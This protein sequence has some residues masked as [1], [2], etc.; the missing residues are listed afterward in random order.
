LS[1]GIPFNTREA[2]PIDTSALSATSRN[3]TDRDIITPLF[4]NVHE[5]IARGYGPPKSGVKGASGSADAAA[6]S[7]LRVAL[8]RFPGVVVPSWRT[9]KDLAACCVG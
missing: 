5:K 8:V 9:V 3:V 1:T 2:V 4:M 7:H 6:R